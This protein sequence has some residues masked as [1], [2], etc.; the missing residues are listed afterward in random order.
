ME[1]FTNSKNIFILLVRAKQEKEIIKMNNKDNKTE[2]NNKDQQQGNTRK[3]LNIEIHKKDEI[4]INSY[5]PTQSIH[6]D[7]KEPEE[8]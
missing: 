5:K 4:S 7:S 2:N 3:E 8:E 1:C 6:R